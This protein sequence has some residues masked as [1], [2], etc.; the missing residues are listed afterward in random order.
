MDFKKYEP[1]ESLVLR[2]FLGLT[3]IFWGYEKLTVSK[4]AEIYPMD[5]GTFMIVD[6][7]TF[8][9]FFGVVQPLLGLTMIA[10]WYTRVSAALLA[11][12]AIMTIIIPGILIDHN[13][14]HFVYAFA[15]AGGAVALLI[16]G[17]STYSIDS[18]RS[19]SS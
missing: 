4:L 11:V 10:G 9:V 2:I 14:P 15:T 19:L 8:L 16:R 1:Y 12:M 13:V 3:L 7:K 17:G 5:Y 6:V 18:A